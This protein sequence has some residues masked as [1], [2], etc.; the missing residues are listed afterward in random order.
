[1]TEKPLLLFV[2]DD[3]TLRMI[4]GRELAK[5][6]KELPFRL[7]EAP[8]GLDA[9]EPLRREAA[10]GRPVLV[11]SDY[12]MPKMGGVEFLRAALALFPRG[13]LRFVFLTSLER[14]EDKRVAL[15]AGAHRFM[16]KPF[17]MA[18]LRR[19]LRSV[20]EDWLRTGAK[21]S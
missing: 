9:L 20:V 1:M 19:E 13:L 3:E 11:L 17:H 16:V 21:A 2:E 6:A 14:K 4:T 7:A 18:D 15:A 10:A 8:D 5:L 12:V